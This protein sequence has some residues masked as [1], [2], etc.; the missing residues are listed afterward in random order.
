MR[1]GG[2]SAD[3]CKFTDDVLG[4]AIGGG[5]PPPS[6]TLRLSCSL[7]SSR[8]KLTI[9]WKI[10]Q[11]LLQNIGIGSI[12]LAD[13]IVFYNLIAGDRDKAMQT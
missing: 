9:D 4:T 13:S 8:L 3:D 5:P 12:F 1:E 6:S 7:A 2:L 11:I 10:Q